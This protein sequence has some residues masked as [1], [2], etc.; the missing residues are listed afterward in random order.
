[1]NL[2]KIQKELH[3]S[4][5]LRDFRYVKR[6]A[7]KKR[8]I[9]NGS[10]LNVS[11]FN[12]FRLF[13]K[14][15]ETIYEGQ[16]DFDFTITP[17]TRKGKP[18]LVVN[19]KSIIL[20]F[21][22][23]TL[24]N[25]RRQTHTI[26]DLLLRIILDKNG[27]TKRLSLGSIQGN[28][29]TL[30]SQEYQSNYFHSH[31]STSAP[32]MMRGTV[33][34]TFKSFCTGSGEINAYRMELNEDGMTEQ[35][36]IAFL[37]QLTTLVSWE[38]LEG[39]PYKYM[40]KIMNK[41]NDISLNPHSRTLSDTNMD[42]YYSRWLDRHKNNDIVPL[43]QFEYTNGGYKLKE[44][45]NLDEV[46]LAGTRNSDNSFCRRYYAY[47]DEE[48]NYYKVTSDSGNERVPNI[49]HRTLIFRGEE[50]RSKIETEQTDSTTINRNTYVIKP[51]IKQY[52]INKINNEINK[53]AIRQS[54]IER[55]QS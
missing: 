36:I 9:I 4:G 30:T 44:N 53:K 31:L 7:D 18:G 46:F 16:W 17:T 51:E 47:K 6:L 35:K 33:L 20:K 28:R 12:D 41:S 2:E 42:T 13:V 11:L 34:R 45:S 8:L 27:D 38:S 1:M 3:L 40:N 37:L 49:N 26:K 10:I 29:L 5:H 43:L 22:E 54:T 25:S 15:V 24:K 55:Y 39:T 23:L 21:D 14:N 52:I 48:G 32:D 50:L 19:I